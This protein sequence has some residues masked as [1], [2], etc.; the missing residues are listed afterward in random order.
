MLKKMLTPIVM[1]IA[2]MGSAATVNADELDGIL[3]IV[4]PAGG[5]DSIFIEIPKDCE[6]CA[7]NI[8]DMKELVAQLG[9]HCGDLEAEL[10]D[11]RND[12]KGIKLPPSGTWAEKCDYVSKGMYLPLLKERQDCR[13]EHGDLI[14]VQR[15]V[16]G[17]CYGAPLYCGN[18]EGFP[19]IYW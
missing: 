4:T 6:E 7:D 2:F 10:E 9:E 16:K 8:A 14:K 19:E 18:I 11:L 12:C 17:Y 5:G 1:G 13:D 15:K 3:A